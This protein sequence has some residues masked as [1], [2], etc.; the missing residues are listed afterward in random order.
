M[1]SV[2]LTEPPEAFSCLLCARPEWQK[3]AGPKCQDC[4]AFKDTHFHPYND[5]PEGANIIV[6]GDAPAPPPRLVLIGGTEVNRRSNAHQTFDDTAGKVVKAAVGRVLSRREYSGVQALYTYA[7]KCALDNANK[8]TITTCSSHLRD[9]IHRTAQRRKQ[10][11][12]TGPLVILACGVDVLTSLGVNVRSEDQAVNRIFENVDVNG[13]PVTIVFTRSLKALGSQDGKFNTLISDVERAASVAAM[14]LVRTLSREEIEKD[15]VYPKTLGEVRSLVDFVIG[16]SEHGVP[17]KDWKIS[18]DTETNTLHPNWDGT[19]LLS[20]SFAWSRGKAA[21][22]AL[23]HPQNTMYDPAAAYEEV[24]RLLGSQKPV[25]WFNGKYDY[26][27]F[28][29]LGWPLGDVGNVYWDALLAEHVLEEDKKK[30]YS[31]KQ[32]TKQFLPE[33]AGYEDKLHDL[34]EADNEKVNVAEPSTE[35]KKKKELKL[36]TIVKEAVERLLAAKLIKSV[37]ARPA[38]LE[39]ELL[40]PKNEALADDLK[41]VLNAKKSGLFRAGAEE[42]EKAKAKKKET[43]GFER[44]PLPELMFYACVDADATRRIA[45]Q[46][47]VRMAEEDARLAK[48]RETIRMQQKRSRDSS[49]NQFE[50]E[51]LCTKPRALFHLAQSDYLPRQ[52]ELAKIEYNGM[53]VD[54]KYLTWGSESL[55]QTIDHTRK[56]IFDLAEGEE[57]KLGSA[58]KLAQLFFGEGYPHPDAEH[59]QAMADAYPGLVTYRGGKI[60]YKP[61]A[62]TAKGAIQTTDGVF[63]SLVTRYKCPL[64]NL[65]LAHKK[66]DKARNTFFANIEAL[67][68]YFGDGKLHAGYGLTSTS[69]GRLASSVNIGGARF[70]AQNIP[71]G[72]IGALRNIQGDLVLDQNGVPV[73]E[74]VK[75][76]KLFIPDDDSYCFGNADAKGAEVSIYAAY[77]HDAALIEALTAG[78]DAHCFFGSECLNPA[79]VAAGLT[80]EARRIALKNA[81]IDDDHAWSYDDFLKGKDGLLSDKAYGKRL[82]ELRDN[83]KRLVFGMLYG[84]GI[85]KIAEITGISH[86]FAKQIQTLLF[87]KFPTIR[88]FMDRTKWELRTF[89]IVEAF[90]GRRR[91]FLVGAGAP[92]DLRAQAERRAINFKVQGTNSDI[93]LSVLCWLAPVIENDLQGRLL[94]TVHDS[95]GFQVPKKYAH[96]LRDIFTEYGTKRVAEAY[97]WMPVPYRWDVELGPSYGEVI[98][99]EKYVKGLPAPL[100]MADLDGYTEDEQFDDLRDPDGFEMPERTR[101]P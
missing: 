75:C 40:D 12:Q 57:F 42:K 17:A 23:W 33:L 43:G 77:S 72:M 64:A 93:V 91:R 14:R 67:A 82:K 28:W 5:G 54:M 98:D 49:Y 74:G 20:V 96:Q 97:P 101:A 37:G 94:L 55:A 65:I 59:A 1:A 48:D 25:I 9:L 87:T 66:A 78:L 38:T 4:P 46:Q 26:K 83:I 32:L 35:G 50:V 16:Y 34:L 79:L 53:A 95:I 18:F 15:F 63:K 41:L 62:Y 58:K 70:N 52:R 6:V 36:P 51:V 99:S 29:K 27:V 89:G 21:S 92:N 73:F 69:T 19:K 81:G 47:V 13:V 84:A 100:P 39:K 88:T 8:K 45:V 31:L 68:L 86:E 7:V 90:N 76:K 30:Y 11:G 10:D 2:T 56:Q 80:G 22:I 44:I 3:K 71:K 61:Q 60:S 24:K 85:K